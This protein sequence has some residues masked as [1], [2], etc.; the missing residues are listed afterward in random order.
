MGR[1]NNSIHSTTIAGQI[2]NRG[3]AFYP[4]EY[5]E[6]FVAITCNNFQ[7]IKQIARFEKATNS[8]YIN[9]IFTLYK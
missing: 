9:K 5:R 8:D 7:M 2:Y 3:T 6:N 4:R 1:F